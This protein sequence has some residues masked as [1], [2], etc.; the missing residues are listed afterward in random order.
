MAAYR[1]QSGHAFRR[2]LRGFSP[3]AAAAETGSQYDVEAAVPPRRRR[4]S[5]S[6]DVQYTRPTA[7]PPL[8]AGWH[9]NSKAG[10]PRRRHRHRHGHPRQDPRRHVRHARLKL[11]LWQAE[12]HAD[13]L[14]TI[15]ARMS[16]RMSVSGSVSASWNASL[17][18]LSYRMR[19][20]ASIAL[21]CG[22]ARHR[23]APRPV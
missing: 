19:C 10:I 14:A 23:M 22:A 12:R 1:H 8:Y 15:L 18:G 5:S 9:K 17:K 13:I 2:K 21:R 6:S 4:R 11:F 20:Y 7:S 3:S 16:T